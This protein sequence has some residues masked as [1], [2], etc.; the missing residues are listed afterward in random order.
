[1]PIVYC[2]LVTLSTEGSL[3]LCNHFFFLCGSSTDHFIDED[4]LHPLGQA[5]QHTQDHAFHVA[6]RVG[7][8]TVVLLSSIVE[9]F[10]NDTH[11]VLVSVK[12]FRS[13]LFQYV[14]I[15][16]PFGEACQQKPYVLLGFLQEQPVVYKPHLRHDRYR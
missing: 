5:R 8:G 2:L 10:E 15:I 14:V 4:L 6:C 9:S 16:R 3:H 7:K 1:M 11:G 12:H 13:C